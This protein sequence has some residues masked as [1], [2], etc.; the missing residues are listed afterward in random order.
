MS[1]GIVRDGGVA[2]VT[3][4]NPPVNALGLAVREALV[5]AVA[6]LEADAAVMAVVLAGAGKLFV[7]GAD[8]TEFDRPIEEPST[9]AVIAAIE[10]ARKPWVAALHGV[11][12]GGGLELAL[13]CHWR[14]AAPGTQLAL[15]EIGL[16]I[17]PG[18]GGTQRLPRLVG[19][20][21]AKEIILT[22]RFVDASEALAIGL[23]N[24][25]VPAADTYTAAQELAARLARGPGLA[26]RA[27]K[28]AVDRGIET[29]LETGLAI[30]R[31]QFAALFA[32]DDR[33][34]G[35]TSFIE[36]GPGKA[37]FTGN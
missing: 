19:V 15:P 10:G 14:M 35:M 22:G 20:A 25:V 21:R 18:A 5:A 36:S 31:L 33:L 24:Q 4:A 13:G 23:V 30:E 28:E 17:I 16:G 7:A 34:I 12:F 26:M 3:I 1:I 11:A 8:I 37:Q 29:D 2:T 9:P 32:T 27:A 6:E